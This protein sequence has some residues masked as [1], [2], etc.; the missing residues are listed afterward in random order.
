LEAIDKEKRK[1]RIS[2]RRKL[3]VLVVLIIAAAL[4]LTN[5]IG[6]ISMLR[7]RKQ[8][9]DVFTM[10]MENNLVNTVSGKA[11]LANAEFE[12]YMSYVASFTD[13]VHGLYEHPERY[14]K[15]EVMPP[16]LEDGEEYT[17]K[18]YLNDSGLNYDDLREECELLGNVEQ[19]FAPTLK[20]CDDEMLAI[21][22]CS[23]SGLEVSYDRDSALMTNPDGK[24]AY[25]DHFSRPWYQLAKE[26][27]DVVFTDIYED[28]YGRGNTITCAAPYYNADNEFAGVIAIDM[29]IDEFYSVLVDFDILPGKL[30]FAFLVDGNG[31]AVSP[32]YRDLNIKDDE[33]IGPEITQKIL[34]GE[35]GVSLGESGIYYAY[36]PI[37]GVNWKLCLHV[38][39]NVILEP[40]QEMSKKIYSSM[41]GF[42]L[43]FIVISIAILFV[44]RK[45]AL[46]ITQPLY[47]LKRDAEEISS[48]N[49]DHVAKVYDN[50]EIGDLAVSFNNMAISLKDYIKNLTLVTAE[51]ERIGAELN[52]ATQIQ[53]DMLPRIFPPFPEKKEFDLYATMSP[54]KEVGGDF[55]DFYLLDDDHLCM[56]MADVSGKGVPA[57][58]FMVI[59]KTLIK[60]RAQLG[61]SP[62][63]ILAYANEQ[64]CEGNDAELFVTVWIA[65]LEIST[66][67]GVAANAGHEYP[68]IKRA[69]GDYEFVKYKHS[70]PVAIVEEAEFE[71]HEFEMHPGDRLFI[72]TDGVPEAT[73]SSNELFGEDRMLAALNANKDETVEKVLENM[74]KSIDEFVGEAPQFDD[75]TML[76][77]NYYGKQS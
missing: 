41:V 21:Y 64:L 2:I 44:V 14:S 18:R 58:L 31:Y 26:K 59:A 60:N 8:A 23:E 51:K 75:I 55:Y 20:A 42:L 27:Q 47:S 5:L 17:I 29:F 45:F 49:L 12:R 57:A 61:G 72:Y 65:I 66:G 74:K 4:F 46:G 3:Q 7:I 32:L 68:V 73:S 56:V 76:T 38:P 24:E 25:F 22:V 48:G 11:D 70:P 16:S 52:V 30:D 54:A 77:L 62:S 34:T 13:Y 50:D 69:G 1:T 53:A 6:V 10:R 71:E 37:Q 33:D 43:V 15:R 67:K 39:Q 40:V 63:E 28:S 19:I 35:T 9:T 36:A